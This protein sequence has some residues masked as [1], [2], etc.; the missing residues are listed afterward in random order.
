MGA[1]LTI[2]EALALLVKLTAAIK[3]AH[4]SGATHIDA[5]DVLAAHKASEK[6]AH[7]K[8]EGILE[9]RFDHGGEG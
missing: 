3:D 5:A 8:A 7:D 6:S 9:K 4:D 1:T 2:A